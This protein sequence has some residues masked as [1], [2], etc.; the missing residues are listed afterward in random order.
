[1]SFSGFSLFFQKLTFQRFKSQLKSLLFVPSFDF[2][3]FRLQKSVGTLKTEYP[4]IQALSQDNEQ[5]VYS[6]AAT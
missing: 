5:G 1:M 3:V 2:S 4:R 6:R